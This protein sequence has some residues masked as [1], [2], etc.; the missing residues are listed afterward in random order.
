MAWTSYKG[1]FLPCPHSESYL[2]IILFSV[3]YRSLVLTALVASSIPFIIIIRFYI[4]S[5]NTN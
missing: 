3:S 5:L 1:S 2:P 4:H